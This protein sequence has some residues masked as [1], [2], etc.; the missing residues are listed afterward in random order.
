MITYLF[1]FHMVHWSFILGQGWLLSNHFCKA[2]QNCLHP[3]FEFVQCSTQ[4]RADA[5]N[6][7]LLWKLPQR[8]SCS[9]NA[10]LDKN[11]FDMFNKIDCCAAIHGQIWMNNIPNERRIIML[12]GTEIN[13]VISFF[14]F[15]KFGVKPGFPSSFLLTLYT[16]CKPY[17]CL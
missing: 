12:S 14:N 1:F 5:W 4:C 3:S 7:A 2:C 13:F 6:V 16:V 9:A 10:N 17:S 8:P 15:E 11:N